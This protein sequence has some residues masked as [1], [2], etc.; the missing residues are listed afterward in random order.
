MSAVFEGISPHI[1]AFFAVFFRVSAFVVLLPGFGEASLSI[2]IKLAVSLAFTAIVYPIVP[3]PM[4]TDLQ[5]LEIVRLVGLETL[6]GFLLGIGVRLLVLG[7]HTAGTIA[8]QSTSLSQILGNAGME[9]LP[10]M[11][12]VLVIGG[13]ALAMVS[14][15]HVKAAALF[16]GS[17]QL[18]P[19][20]AGIGG[21]GVAQWG[22][23]KVSYVFRLAFTLAVP[24]VILSMLYN[25]TLGVI[26][27]AMPQLMV[28]FV[29]AP[30][31][32]LGGLFVLFAAAPMMLEL[33]MQALDSY[34]AN[35]VERP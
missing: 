18:F 20:G 32:T 6:A 5:P 2:R 1:F 31:I 3:V 27:K 17:Y 9:P 21:E 30:A 25:L 28:A 34:L 23:A 10:A 22:V 8:A 11:G 7:L 14:G 19:F 26:N 13:I 24:F 29:G 4:M 12:H 35:P 33:W 15:L 16:V